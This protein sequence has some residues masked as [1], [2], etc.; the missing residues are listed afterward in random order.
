MHLFK[1]KKITQHEEENK[2][3]TMTSGDKPVFVLAILWGR[4]ILQS[5]QEDIVDKVVC[6]I[7]AFYL[8]NHT[9]VYMHYI[10]S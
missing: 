8:F 5:H 1:H 7:Y 9:L 6:V 4:P 2:I 3:F 10:N